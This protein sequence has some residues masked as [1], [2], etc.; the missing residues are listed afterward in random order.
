[1]AIGNVKVKVV[2]GVED[3]VLDEVYEVGDEVDVNLDVVAVTEI[4]EPENIAELEDD[5]AVAPTPLGI[6]IVAVYMMVS[7]VVN[8]K[9]ATVELFVYDAEEQETLKG[10]LLLGTPVPRE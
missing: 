3:K 2:M 8:D 6:G 4:T 9:V 5:T 7:A 10:P 1:M